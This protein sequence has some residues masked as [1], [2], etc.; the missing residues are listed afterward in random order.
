MEEKIEYLEPKDLIPKIRPVDKYLFIELDPKH[1]RAGI[2]WLA[3][4]E[5]QITRV[6]KIL[7]IGPLVTEGK[8][9]VGDKVLFGLW[10]GHNI[11]LPKYHVFEGEEGGVW[12]KL[13]PENEIWAF[14][15]E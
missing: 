13:I 2:L 9:K 3:K 4:K 1:E 7:A 15:D 10:S 5:R 6:G 14:I 8:Y 12:L 11:N